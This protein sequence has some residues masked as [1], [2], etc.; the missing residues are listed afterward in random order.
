M[1]PKIGYPKIWSS[2]VLKTRGDKLGKTYEQID[3]GMHT[4]IILL[5]HNEC[6]VK[7]IS[8]A[9]ISLAP[10]I[11]AESGAASFWIPEKPAVFAREK[12]P[13]WPLFAD[14]LLWF[15]MFPCWICNVAFFCSRSHSM[16]AISPP[17]GCVKHVFIFHCKKRAETNVHMFELRQNVKIV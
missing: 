7:S 4:K 14:I 13:F 17:T 2:Y 5:R 11:Q 16:W 10:R 9:A 3:F 6:P 1:R 12:F 15:A 8:M